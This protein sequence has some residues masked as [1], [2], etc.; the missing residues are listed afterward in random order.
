MA[1]AKSITEKYK[2]PGFDFPDFIIFCIIIWYRLYFIK[3]F[4]PEY[5][6]EI[7]LV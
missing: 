7:S 1:F 6:L 2:N 4:S 3:N 5:F